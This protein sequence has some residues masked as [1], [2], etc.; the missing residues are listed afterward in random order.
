MRSRF[1]PNQKIA[2]PNKGNATNDYHQQDLT[3]AQEIGNRWGEGNALCNFAATLIKLGQCAEA[4]KD[5]QAALEISK[6][7][8]KRTITQRTNITCDV[9]VTHI[10][11]E[12]KQD[13]LKND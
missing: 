6:E 1:V 13:I 2:P 3:I 5:L 7:V 12:S 4:L 9:S 11:Q 8:S 10:S